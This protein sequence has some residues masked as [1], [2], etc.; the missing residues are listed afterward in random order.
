MRAC[1]RGE[2]SS[3]GHDYQPV[4]VRDRASRPK[5]VV[6]FELLTNC[7]LYSAN[8]CVY[9]YVTDYLE[10]EE[11]TKTYTT[12]LD[13]C[14]HLDECKMYIKRGLH[15]PRT[16]HGKTLV[17]YLVIDTSIITGSSPTTAA[18][19]S[20]PKRASVLSTTTTSPSA[21]AA[22]P[23]KSGKKAR[24]LVGRNVDTTR[25]TMHTVSSLERQLGSII[26]DAAQQLMQHEELEKQLSQSTQDE[27][28]FAAPSS[29]PTPAT[30]TTTT[31]TTHST[32][33][34]ALAS[35]SQ[36][37]PV[38][39]SAHALSTRTNR[40]KKT[41]W[42]AATL[43]GYK[44]IACPQ[45][46]SQSPRAVK[47]TPTRRSA[48]AAAVATGDTTLE[49]IVNEST[50]Q[51]STNENANEN[52]EI[53]AAAAAALVTIDGEADTST[54]DEVAKK[55]GRK[56]KIRQEEYKRLPTIKQLMQQG[57]NIT[58]SSSSSP[59]TA[60]VSAPL[61][62]TVVG[63][64]PPIAS[65]QRQTQQQQKTPTVDSSG[66]GEEEHNTSIDLFELI[67]TASTSTQQAPKDTTAPEKAATTTAATG[68]VESTIMISDDDDEFDSLFGAVMNSANND[69]AAT[70][71]A[72]QS[73]P[74]NQ[75]AS[76]TRSL[77]SRANSSR[78][79]Q[80]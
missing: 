64:R 79:A 74:K 11:L 60:N 8:N 21:A 80:F 66:N 76:Q 16:I 33:K 9:V 12:F 53:L 15:V 6:V 50:S 24:L 4:T 77:R 14:K 31:T 69:D 75:A 48:A 56:K 42:A 49:S 40:G 7:H 26:E 39:P 18:A 32:L 30:T 2:P 44:A 10:D 67:N 47:I 17:D 55:R 37:P 70:T 27:F 29:A 51:R 34:S 72:K 22:S 28:I 63:P 41:A 43:A 62:A 52:A 73:D 71:P 65:E 13:E 19:T 68:T 38:L 54:S 46:A 58:L 25:P 78:L 57:N 3:V 35:M 20:N 59:S 45:Q 1:V 36:Q 61:P 23:A 5:Y